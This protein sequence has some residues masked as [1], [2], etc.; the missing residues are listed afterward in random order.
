LGVA[1]EIPSKPALAG[2]RDFSPLKRGVLQKFTIFFVFFIYIL[3]IYYTHIH[4][5]TLYIFRLNFVVKIEKKIYKSTGW[6]ILHHQIFII[7]II[8]LLFYVL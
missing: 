1:A 5:F 8:F 6:I 7:S 4:Y 3:Y 2:L